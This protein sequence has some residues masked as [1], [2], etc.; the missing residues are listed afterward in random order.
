MLTKYEHA[1][2]RFP[3]VLVWV[4]AFGTPHREH[5]A[6]LPT[7]LATLPTALAVACVNRCPLRV[8]LGL[9]LSWASVPSSFTFRGVEIRNI[10]SAVL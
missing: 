6:N 10:K 3:S 4:G 2:K 7:A 5:V 9:C 8:R 1:H